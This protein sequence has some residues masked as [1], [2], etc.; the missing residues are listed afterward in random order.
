MAKQRA[1]WFGS[2]A[3][4]TF[5]VFSGGGVGA[6]LA[7]GIPH[8]QRLL[9]REQATRDLRRSV[10]ADLESW[11]DS[12]RLPPEQ[13]V[14]ALEQ[15]TKL[16]GEHGVDSQ[17]AAKLDYDH[18]RVTD[19][20]IKAGGGDGLVAAAVRYS[21]TAPFR[22]IKS[23]TLLPYLQVMRT[24]NSSQFTKQPAEI[25]AALGLSNPEPPAK[26]VV[27]PIPAESA[28]YV[29]RPGRAA[30]TTLPLEPR[31]EHVPPGTWL[32]SEPGPARWPPPAPPHPPA[33]RATR[34]FHLDQHESGE[35]CPR[36]SPRRY[37]GVS[38]RSLRKAPS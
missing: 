34:H 19:E 37:C 36:T 2:L 29:H 24:E 31:E 9:E 4:A 38:L 30:E 27:G 1:E 3:T 10:Q 32:A 20:V 15:A 11:A 5:A 23:E 12:E 25:I 17:V 18:Y 35:A 13:V 33:N 28:G 21:Y 7:A 6:V 14:R 26:V 16:I 8:A 22:E